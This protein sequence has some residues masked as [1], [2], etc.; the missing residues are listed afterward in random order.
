MQRE[1]MDD[2][3]DGGGLAGSIETADGSPLDA[4]AITAL[5][6]ALADHPLLQLGAL[7][8]LARGFAGTSHI[9]LAR[10]G[11][12]IDSA[13]HTLS[14]SEARRNVDEVFDTLATPG[15]WLAIFYAEHDP[16]YA[17]LLR[18]AIDGFAHQI[19]PVDPGIHGMNMFIFIATPPTVTPFHI[20]REN[21]IN[22]QILG[23]KRWRIWDPQDRTAVP[24]EAI[25][26]FFARDSLSKLHFKPEFEAR[27]R[28]L[29]VGPGDGV[30]LPATSAHA[31]DT[32]FAQAQGGSGRD[33]I[34][35]NV[36]LT[37]FTRGTRRRANLVLARD[38][39][40]RRI[41]SA[42]VDA[43]PEWACYRLA[44]TLIRSRQILLRHPLPRGT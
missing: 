23:R 4:R 33:A 41:G 12:K 28:V 20:D 19:E 15:S 6:H 37:Y 43:L 2:V 42:A 10:P 21:N 25:E 7:H 17:Q 29:E 26:E 11:R 9:K 13:F 22:L 14:E 38:F 1:P 27:A 39:L 3:L 30:Y 35:V 44:R 8:E 34:A 36:A 31:V 16:T 24:D 40:R 32:E 5:R 18:D